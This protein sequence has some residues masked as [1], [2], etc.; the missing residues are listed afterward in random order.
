M[1]SVETEA[2][3]DRLDAYMALEPSDRIRAALRA[4]YSVC[5]R[6]SHYGH[7]LRPLVETGGARW[8]SLAPASFGPVRQA[9]ETGELVPYDATW[10]EDPTG[11]SAIVD[12]LLAGRWEDVVARAETL[13]GED[14][15]EPIRRRRGMGWVDAYRARSAPGD[16]QARQRR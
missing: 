5:Y 16:R 15:A 11:E 2:D 7:E 12:D 3:L 8:V 4:L 10:S 14:T 9:L 1:L 13:D 6:T